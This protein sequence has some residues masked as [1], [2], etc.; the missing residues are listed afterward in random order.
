MI[1]AWLQQR[2]RSLRTAY[3]T[4]PDRTAWSRCGALFGGYTLL[5]LT[6]GKQTGFLTPV[7]PERSG[8]LCLVL[9]VVAFVFPALSEETVFRGLLVPHPDE[10]AT[11]QQVL[12]ASAGSLLLFIAYHP[13]NGMTFSRANL[14]LFSNPVFLSLAGLLGFVCT[15]AYR[16]SG[17][18]WPSV[19]IHWLTVVAWILFLGGRCTPLEQVL[20]PGACPDE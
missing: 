13:L 18:L 12:V 2:L 17:S 10:D 19:L 14:R 7:R 11:H 4:L 9:P 8:R 5:A 6:I 3:T 15:A 16:I 20:I 1:L